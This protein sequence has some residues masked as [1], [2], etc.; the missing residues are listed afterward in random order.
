MK[1][2]TIFFALLQTI[3]A[4]KVSAEIK[5]LAKDWNTIANMTVDQILN[6]FKSS[7]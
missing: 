3:I 2:V 1:F 6:T 7:N 5:A 4:V